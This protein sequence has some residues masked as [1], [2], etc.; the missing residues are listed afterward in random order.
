MVSHL[1]RQSPERAGKYGGGRGS[2]CVLRG[3]LRGRLRMRNS[4]Q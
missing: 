3:P 1:Q 4:V 2:Q